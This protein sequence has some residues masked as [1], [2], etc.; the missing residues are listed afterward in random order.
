M[1]GFL[2]DRLRLVGWQRVFNIQCCSI[3]GLGVLL[4]SLL[5]E[6]VVVL[7]VLV[8]VVVVVVAAAVA[9]IL[10]VTNPKP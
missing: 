6:V 3:E 8:A 5:L 4:L 1:R 9:V 10:P 2:F 7:V